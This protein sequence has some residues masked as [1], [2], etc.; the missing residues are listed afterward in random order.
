M[1]WDEKYP[2]SHGIFLWF[3]NPLPGRAAQTCS[4]QQGGQHREGEEALGLCLLF[5]TRCFSLCKLKI[6]GIAKKV[7]VLPTGQYHAVFSQA[8]FFCKDLGLT[9]C[10]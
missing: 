10:F 9:K 6:M 3:P 2:L 8:P 4:R 7:K 5:P 1:N